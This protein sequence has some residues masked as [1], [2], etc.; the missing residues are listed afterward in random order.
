MIPSEDRRPGVPG[1]ME[2]V[3]RCTE[4]SVEVE[5]TD[6]KGNGWEEGR[7]ERL[8]WQ[9]R[10]DE[11][12]AHK[13]GTLQHVSHCSLNL[14]LLAHPLSP[15]SPKYIWH[16]SDGVARSR[17]GLGTDSATL[18]LGAWVSL[19]HSVTVQDSACTSTRCL[20][21]GS[22]LSE[23]WHVCWGCMAK[24]FV[25]RSW[26]TPYPRLVNTQGSC[27]KEPAVVLS[28]PHAGTL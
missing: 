18:D 5:G 14:G 13:V 27:A 6:G 22:V 21:G 17:A 9:E 28:L 23:L 26:D 10:E 19:A 16:G 3:W 1:R 2:W 24:S 8:D 20:R 11:G 12:C 4:S 15:H 25:C 7:G